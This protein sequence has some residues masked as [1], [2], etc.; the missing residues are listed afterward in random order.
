MA[1]V[2]TMRE[3]SVWW[4]AASGTGTSWA[5]ASAPVS[6]LFGFVQSFSHTSGQTITTIKERGT[7]HHHK[8]T[9]V[10]PIQVTLNFLWTGTNTT[11]ASGSGA[12]VPMH[13]LEFKAIAP[14][15]GNTGVY[16]QFHGA[17]LQD[18]NFTENAE[19]NTIDYT[20]P[21]LA[22]NGPTGSGYLS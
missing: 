1:E 7:P 4:V 20:F 22:M 2:R 12:S 21:A 19:G 10:A 11:P 9:D 16:Y 14:E 3:G 15:N 18:N 8:V 17:A 5:T 6:G 13:H